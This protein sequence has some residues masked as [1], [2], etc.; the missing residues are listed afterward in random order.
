MIAVF[1]WIRG[2]IFSTTSMACVPHKQGNQAVVSLSGVHFAGASHGSCGLLRELVLA[3]DPVEV[4]GPL[5][6]IGSVAVSGFVK[7]PSADVVPYVS[8]FYPGRSQLQGL[9]LQPRSFM[10]AILT[11]VY[12]GD[13]EQRL[14]PVPGFSQDL[15]SYL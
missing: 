13:Y 8:F 14:P 6:F 2:L 4:G 3:G 10:P 9:F 15:E 12:L 1:G 5:K 11:L 7:E